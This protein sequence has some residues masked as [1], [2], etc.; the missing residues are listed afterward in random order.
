MLSSI[1][2]HLLLEVLFQ[3]GF[4]LLEH[5]LNE[6]LSIPVQFHVTI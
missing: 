6:G 5:F 1:I 2:R 3:L 4:R